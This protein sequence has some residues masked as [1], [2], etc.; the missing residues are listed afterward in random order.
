MFAINNLLD[1][2]LNTERVFV[3]SGPINLVI[4]DL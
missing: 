1:C 3:E 4:Q 2:K